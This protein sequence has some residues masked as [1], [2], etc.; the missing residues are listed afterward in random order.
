MSQP[1]TSGAP[2]PNP[3][4]AAPVATQPPAANQ[5]PSRLAPRL[6]FLLVVVVAG[7]AGMTFWKNA[8]SP[9]QPAAT[10]A[11]QQPV[12][13]P[14][15]RHATHRRPAQRQSNHVAV[16][17][18]GQAETASLVRL[19]ESKPDET[20]IDVWSDRPVLDVTWDE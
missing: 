4:P 18:A 7:L 12:R 10:I 9:D 19:D 13:H 1:P 15:T 17:S 6:V 11:I 2:A 5:R 3:A 8:C 14:A 16:T 20:T